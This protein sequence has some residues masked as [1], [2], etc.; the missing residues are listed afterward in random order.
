S[1]V[2]NSFVAA[3]AVACAAAGHTRQARGA[4]A[5]IIG[6]DLAELPT[7]SSWLAAMTAVIEAAGLLEDHAAAT[8]AYRL[9]LPFAHLPVMASTAVACL[10]SAQ[11]PL[12][13]ACLV[14]R[15][16]DRAVEHF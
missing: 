9:L 8:R 11:H 7:S 10:G 12:G 13:V 1:V 3:Q 15:D 16:G 14:T 4:L 2:D 6:R 5:R